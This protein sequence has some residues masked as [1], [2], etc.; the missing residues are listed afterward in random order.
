MGL[1]RLQS[2][3][4]VSGTP[5]AVSLPLFLCCHGC[6]VAPV[7]LCSLFTIH[8]E[9]HCCFHPQGPMQHSGS[10]DISC[11]WDCDS[12]WQRG[13]YWW[14]SWVETLSH[15]VDRHICWPGYWRLSRW[16][17]GN[18]SFDSCTFIPAPPNPVC[19]KVSSWRCAEGRHRHQQ[20]N[21]EYL[22]HH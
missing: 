7:P 8:L 4:N 2:Y 19:H 16:H 6:T 15:S 22:Y 21:I 13:W 1:L 9:S 5:S 17:F 3:S 14:L 12:R 20:R 18:G 10:Q 11:T